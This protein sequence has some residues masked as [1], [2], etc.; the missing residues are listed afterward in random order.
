MSKIRIGVDPDTKKHGV[1]VYIDGKLTALFMLTT[2]EVMDLCISYGVNADILFSIEDNNA[3]GAIYKKRLNAKDSLA[4]KM[5]KA[6]DVGK[7]KQAQIELQKMLDHIGIKYE[8]QKPSANFKKSPQQLKQFTGWDKRSNE[9]TRS[10]AWF[11]Y[12]IKDK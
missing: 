2:M 7:V 11:G 12:L 6:Q 4:V 3:I 5:A 1:A 9:D 10:A 8:L